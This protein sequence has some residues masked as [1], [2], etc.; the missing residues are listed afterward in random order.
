MQNVD[1]GTFDGYVLV[2]QTQGGWGPYSS[3][4]DILDS[5]I[6]YN[7]AD[8]FHIV[9]NGLSAGAQGVWQMFINYPTY[10][11]YINPMSAV[12]IQ[13]A[14]T[15]FVNSVKYTPIWHLHG[16]LDG[17]PT[18]QTAAAVL[19]AMQAGGANYQDKDYT[20]LGHDTWDSTWLEPAFYP[21]IN[22][23]Y[24]SN[25]WPFFGGKDPILPG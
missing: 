1:N 12:F 2:P 16:G 25:P 21:R 9:N 24:M 13:Y 23:A 19:A 14:D 4:K 6:A 20:T 5:L 3:I 8:P 22:A 7:K 17:D 18:P 15:A 10:I 11:C